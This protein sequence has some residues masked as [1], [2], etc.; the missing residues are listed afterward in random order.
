[1]KPSLD[2]QLLQGLKRG[3]PALVDLPGTSG[4][5]ARVFWVTLEGPI[6]AG[7]TELCKVLTPRLVEHFGKDRVFYVAEPIDEL[8][9]SGLFQ[10]YQR[11][12]KRWA[13]EFQTTFFNKRTDYFREAY[14]NMIHTLA[15]TRVTQDDQNGCKTAILFS[16]RSI[17]SDTCF[18]RV[19]Y[20]CGHCS[21]D[22]LGRYLD[23]NSKW[24]E[25]YRGVV[26]GL[27]VYCRAGTERTGIID[28]CQRRIRERKREAEEDLVTPEY[29]GLVLKEHDDLFMPTHKGGCLVPG[30]SGKELLSIPVVVV[31][32]TENYRDDERVAL[33][34]SGEL[35]E[36][37]CESMGPMPLLPLGHAQ[38]VNPE[39]W[40]RPNG[41]SSGIQKAY[42][43]SSNMPFAQWK[44][45]FAT[46]GG[47][48]PV[49]ADVPSAYWEKSTGKYLGPVLVEEKE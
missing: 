19:Q 9:R 14:D 28:L 3:S 27:V 16:E 24:R 17:V 2:S 47:A 37:I 43:Q 4:E 42:P 12:P 21:E 18:M 35:L 30:F 15:T 11:D 40:V 38:L 6:G 44:A 8:M 13:F 31:D 5:K 26:P 20:E 22:T 49:H 39:A 32:T 10:D 36:C 25:L 29:N 41:A 1:M 46:I 34:K 23:L 48:G 45:R 7:K 33:K